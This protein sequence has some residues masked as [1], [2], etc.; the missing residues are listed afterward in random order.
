MTSSFNSDIWPVC[1]Q[2]R[3]QPHRVYRST[4]R[5]TEGRLLSSSS[6]WLVGGSWVLESW[7]AAA[8]HK[9]YF[10]TCLQHEVI[11]KVI[12]DLNSTSDDMNLW[13]RSIINIDSINDDIDLWTRFLQRN[14]SHNRNCWSNTRTQCHWLELWQIFLFCFDDDH[15]CDSTS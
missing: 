14:L 9:T 10:C 6:P 7:E 15:L 13:R 5:R 12:R 8:V 11:H 1:L 3:R 2:E 4:R